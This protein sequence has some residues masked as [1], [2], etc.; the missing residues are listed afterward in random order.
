MHDVR[1][2]YRFLRCTG[3]LVDEDCLSVMLYC[4]QEQSLLLSRAGRCL[5]AEALRSYCSTNQL[6]SK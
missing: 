6:T 2:A 5:G 4:A 1:G 3:I